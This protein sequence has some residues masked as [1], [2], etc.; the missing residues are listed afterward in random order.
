MH[1]FH[2]LLTKGAATLN[3]ELCLSYENFRLKRVFLMTVGCERTVNYAKQLHSV[4]KRSDYFVRFSG[5]FE[6]DPAF[7]T[8]SVSAS[9]STWTT[10]VPA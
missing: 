10:S 7:Y 5:R 8:S 3:L 1:S 6:V 4:L 2:K 9:G